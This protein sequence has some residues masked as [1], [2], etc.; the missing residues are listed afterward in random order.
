MQ[1]DTLWKQEL[2]QVEGSVAL[3]ETMI[4]EITKSA[5][6]SSEVTKRGRPARLSRPFLTIGI[7]WCLLRVIW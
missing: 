6:R 4:Q 3:M 5:P 1:N 2:P 7:L